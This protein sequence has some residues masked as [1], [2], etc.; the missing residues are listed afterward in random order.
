MIYLRGK[1]WY[2]DVYPDGSK[3]QRKRVSTGCTVGEKAKAELVAVRLKNGEAVDGIRGHAAPGSTKAGL[4][5]DQALDRAWLEEWRL[6]KDTQSKSLWSKL[7][8]DRFGR[9]TPLADIDD[10][11][12]QDWATDLLGT[13]NSNATVNRKLAVLARLF[14]LAYQWGA[15]DRKPRFPRYAEKDT[16]R[17]FLQ[18]DE[19]E[20][21]IAQEPNIDLRG[22]WAFLRDTACR[23][24]EAMSLSWQSIRGDVAIFADRK[25]GDT[26][27]VPLSA[28]CVAELARVKAAGKSKPFPLSYS[29][30]LIRWRE[31]CARAC[32]E[33][34]R[35][36]ALHIV[37]HTTATELVS[38]GVNLRV[39]QQ[40]LGHGNIEVTERYA[41]MTGTGIREALLAL[42][43]E[44]TV[45]D[46]PREAKIVTQGG[47][48]VPIVCD[49][50]VPIEPSLVALTCGDPP[51]CQEQALAQQG[52]ARR[53]G[54]QSRGEVAEWSIVPDSK[55]GETLRDSVGSDTTV[56]F[57]CDMFAPLR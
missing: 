31:A 46:G 7:I 41:K 57:Q 48:T 50:T 2:T 1:F 44:D 56:P 52:V 37:R 15:I 17:G 29:L 30:Y 34:P 39:V 18:P 43:R 55:S 6:Q 45:A 35:G 14:A 20:R 32:V 4:T 33:L 8:R 23:I 5:L 19:V 11:D 40:V 27:G 13:G 53:R 38:S 10:H 3:G 16:G 28:R 22:T 36:S 42:K 54:T 49:Y 21:V 51:E 26:I 25:G 24:G 9:S 12:I 47:S